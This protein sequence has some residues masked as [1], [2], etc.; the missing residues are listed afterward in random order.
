MPDE[1]PTWSGDPSGFESFATSCR[2]YEASLKDSERKLA[3]PRIWQ[4][5]EGAAKSVVKH[6][7]PKDFATEAGMNKLLS[8][9][10]ESL[11]Q[12][13]PIPDSFSRLEKWTGLRRNG[14]ESIPQLLVREEELF[15]ELQQA[16]QRAR[17]E[18]LKHEVRSMGVG[19]SEHDPPTSPTRSPNVTLGRQAERE[20]EP[21]FRAAEP[22]PPKDNAGFFENELRGYRL[23]KASKLSSAERQHVMTLTKNSTH[24]ELIRQ[25]L[26]SLFADGAEGGE[27]GARHPRRTVWF[28]ED[29]NPSWDTWEDDMRSEEVNFWDEEAYWA[30][31][32]PSSTWAYEDDGD[33]AGG[34]DGLLGGEDHEPTAE[35]LEGEKRLEEAYTLATEAN[36]TL[37]EAK[38]AVARVRAARGYYNPAGVKGATGTSSKGKKGHPNGKGKGIGG[39]GPCF[40]CG[41]PGH[42]YLK[43]PDRWSRGGGGKG[44]GTPSSSP[45]SKGSSMSKGKGKKGKIRKGKTYFTDYDPEY[46]YP[47]VNVLSMAEDHTIEDLEV[48]KVIVDTGA[49]ESVA[50]VRAMARVLDAHQMPYDIDLYDRPRF[51]FGNGEHQRAISKI[52]LSTFSFGKLSFTLFNAR[53]GGHLIL[54]L[55]EHRIPLR[56]LLMR[57]NNNP[58]TRWPPEDDEQD[59]DSGGDDQS[60]PGQRKRNRPTP[61]PRPPVD[62]TAGLLAATTAATEG[63]RGATSAHEGAD[64]LETDENLS[65]SVVQSPSVEVEG[66]PLM[67]APTATA[68]GL[69]APIFAGATAEPEIEQPPERSRPPELLGH[70]LRLGDDNHETMDMDP[71]LPVEA[72]ERRVTH[73]LHDSQEILEHDECQSAGPHVEGPVREESVLMIHGEHDASDLDERLSSLAQRLRDLRTRSSGPSGDESQGMPSCHRYGSSPC[74]LALHGTTSPRKGES[75]QVCSLAGMQQVRTTTP[76]HHQGH[77]TRRDESHWSDSGDGERGAAGTPRAVHCHGNEREDLQRK[78]DGAARKDLGGVGRLWSD[79]RSGEGGRE[80][81]RGTDE[82]LGMRYDQDTEEVSKENDKSRTEI[83]ITDST[84]IQ[85]T[86]ISRQD[87]SEDRD[88]DEIVRNDAEGPGLGGDGQRG[89]RRVR[90]GARHG[91]TGDQGGEG[92]GRV[93][94]HLDALWSAL[95]GLRSRMQPAS[96][97]DGECQPRLEAEAGINSATTTMSP[98]R[99][100]PPEQDEPHPINSTTN[101]ASTT[102]LDSITN[103]TEELNHVCT[104]CSTCPI[105]RSGD[106]GGS[107][108]S[109][110]TEEIAT[111]VNMHEKQ[112]RPSLARRVAMAAAMAVTLMEPVRELVGMV[113]PTVDVMEIACAPNSNLSQV[114]IDKGY[115]TQRIHYL[116]GYDLDSRKGTVKLQETIHEKPPKLAWVS[117]RCTRLSS[118]Q[119][120]TPRTPEQMDK[121]LKRRGRDLNRCEEIVSGLDYV[122]EAGGD[123]AWEWP[124]GAVSG[125]RSRAISKLVKLIRKHGRTP[126]WVKIDGCQYGLEW[127]GLPLKKSWTILTSNRNLWLTLNKRCDRTHEHA[128]C[129][130]PAAEAS[131]YY[132]DKMCRDV[133]KAL[134]FSWKQDSR[135]LEKETENYLLQINDY[136]KAG[137]STSE[138]LPRAP[139]SELPG[140]RADGEI[141]ALSRKRLDMETAPTGKRLEAVK[142]LML[143]VHRAS[144]HAGMS[145]LVQLLRAR[146]SPG[147]ALELAANL[148]CPDCKEASKPRPQPPASTGEQPC[149]FEQ[150]GTDVFEYEETNGA[151]HKL[152]IWRDRGSGLTMIDHLAEFSS[153][154]WEPKTVD[155][156][157]SLTSWLMTYPQPKWILTDAARYYTSNEFLN[158]LG[159]SGVGLTVAPAEAHWLMGPEES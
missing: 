34:D 31:W 145:N 133:L 55:K 79:D 158:Y 61:V 122:L 123:V 135:S 103:E 138:L 87:R 44:K 54:D 25:A 49:T 95:N 93:R 17:S 35:E 151:K 142:Q 116:N 159:R 48:S 157:R 132:P 39:L 140:P 156:I 1:I 155:I 106:G 58:G 56:M 23:L 73:V 125:W 108:A 26:R 90:G 38:Q 53:G 16:L 114:F 80:A 107:G 101:D 47:E 62:P 148:E 74:W 70:E 77:W 57:F 91:Q 113:T 42:G 52:S 96:S 105:T 141:L 63:P 84:D 36:R 85:G 143:R 24:F 134:E 29:P 131:S 118:L 130:G 139:Q 50:G 104:T 20:E 8:V 15:V 43:C 154:G 124:S 72:P 41:Q 68:A 19:A 14:G 153:G 13:L 65:P 83:P 94:G 40:I 86:G 88:G 6:L 51:R 97:E 82:L 150:L 64:A 120:L 102:T 152:I 18:R 33:Y 89:D 45:S 59:D 28:A 110:V 69:D 92:P 117:F 78:A 115:S 32:S 7:E 21:D 76:V 99:Q 146:G 4:K 75:K 46:W 147:W 66:P 109:Y 98:T 129:R 119:N 67:S 112:V 22:G 100:L 128:E 127:K 11:L 60:G 121:F 5:L 27:D 30:D 9:L 149:I 81:G 10:R 126:Y 137:E 71:E 37:T 111:M 2:W 3:A 12:K 136:K 144:G